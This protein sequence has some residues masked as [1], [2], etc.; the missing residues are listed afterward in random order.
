MEQSDFAPLNYFYCYVCFIA[1]F[2]LNKL[3]VSFILSSFSIKIMAQILITEPVVYKIL[4][5]FA[6]GLLLTNE[7]DVLV[8]QFQIHVTF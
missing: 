8:Q 7:N 1:P 4:S 5:H 3:H 6:N 2:F